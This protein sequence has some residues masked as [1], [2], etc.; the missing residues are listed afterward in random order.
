MKRLEQLYGVEITVEKSEL[1]R[2]NLIRGKISIAM[3]LDYA[4]RAL[5][6]I[7]PFDY[8]QVEY[9]RIVIK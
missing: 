7:A 2:L 6:K 5:Q 4:L 3:G 1:P 9:D 8:E